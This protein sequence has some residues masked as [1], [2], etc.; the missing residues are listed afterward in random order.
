MGL[1]A[2]LFGSLCYLAFLAVFIY[3]VAFVGDL[4]VVPSLDHGPAAPW[5]VALGIE[6]GL[7]LLFGLQH[8]LMARPRFKRALARVLPTALE[9][10][11]YV[12]L[13]SLALAILFACWRPLPR[14]LWEVRLPAGRLA[15]WGLFWAGVGLALRSTFLISHA[16]LFGLRQAWCRFRQEPYQEPLFRAGTLYGRVRHPLMLGFLLTFWA[17]PRM[18]LGHL[19]FAGGM[20]AYI[21]LGTLLEE[22]D[23]AAKLGPAYEAYR[24]QVP[25]FFPRF[26]R[27]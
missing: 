7:L 15:L 14:L 19:V 21:L 11:T 17:T 9:R 16:D 6:L 24:R 5:A 25:M 20:S 4:G 1:L 26:W 18:T 22:R 12:L 8:S 23:L 27:R 3:L 13:S 10:S 2:L